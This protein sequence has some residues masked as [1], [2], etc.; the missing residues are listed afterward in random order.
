MVSEGLHRRRLKT[1]PGMASSGCKM[2]MGLQSNAFA[3]KHYLL[4]FNTIKKSTLFKLIYG[5]NIFPIKFPGCPKMLFAQKH[6]S[7]KPH[8]SYTLVIS[9]WVTEFIW[10]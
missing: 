6:C 2:C 10:V 1:S 3:Q 4:L 5:I 7:G 9:F 8:T